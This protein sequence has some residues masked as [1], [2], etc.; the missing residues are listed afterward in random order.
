MFTSLRTVF[1]LFKAV[2]LIGLF[3]FLCS[4]WTFN[5]DINSLSCIQLEICFCHCVGYFFLTEVDVYCIQVNILLISWDSA[6][7]LLILFLEWLKY[8][9]ETPCFIAGILKCFASL[10]L[11]TVYVC[12]YMHAC[13]GQRT[14]LD[15]LL[16]VLFFFSGWTWF[17][18]VQENTV[19]VLR[20]AGLSTCSGT[21]IGDMF[22]STTIRYEYL[23]NH[24]FKFICKS[25]NLGKPYFFEMGI[26]W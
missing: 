9:W 21:M 8:H 2:L 18:R 1:S 20:S 16:Q 4:F 7:Q 5:L 6:C 24:V 14:V 3:D 26:V 19:K 23:S 25:L 17:G 10:S 13:G 12:H 22:D 15:V 11:C